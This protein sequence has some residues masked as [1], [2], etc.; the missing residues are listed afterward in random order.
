MAQQTQSMFT[1]A[2]AAIHAGDKSRARE[3]L[4][5]LL[6]IEPS[7]AEYWLW[8][9]AAVPTER[10]R[11][12][13]LKSALKHDPS[14][15]AA[16]RGLIILGARKPDPAELNAAIG[17]PKRSTKGRS[18]APKA[19]R[20]LPLQWI[21]GGAALFTVVGFG[22]LL[23]LYFSRQRGAAPALPPIMF[24]DTPLAALPTATVTPVP[25]ELRINR[26]AIPAEFAATPLAFFIEHT[27]TPT[28]FIGLTPS[29]RYEAYQ[30]A[31][32]A[33]NRAD[34]DEALILINQVLE[35]EPEFAGAHF[36]HGEILR[37]ADKPYEAIRAYDRAIGYQP[38][39]PAAYLGSARAQLL[40]DPTAIP[41]AFQLA[42]N[43]DPLLTDAYLYMA[44]YH[45]DRRHYDKAEEI[46][47]AAVEAGA[48][49]PALRIDLSEAQFL[50]NK[51][52]AALENAV[53]GSADDPA[54]LKG[55]LVLGRAF[56]AMGFYYDALPPLQ[57]FLTYHNEDHRAWAAIG[58]AYLNT[59]EPELALEAFNISLA[60]RDHAPAFQGRGDYYFQQND[61]SS[62]ISDYYRARQFGPDSADLSIGIGKTLYHLGSRQDALRELNAVIASDYPPAIK[63]EAHAYLAMMFETSNP[64]FIPDA[65]ANWLKVLS[66]PEASPELR[67]MA[68]AQLINLQGDDYRSPT[69]APISTA[70][71][72]PEAITTLPAPT[73]AA[74]LTQTPPVVPPTPTPSPTPRGLVP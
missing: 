54:S 15:R 49:S 25:A 66:I 56:V 62:A 26:T 45:S 27:Q 9:S 2:I 31:I 57:T 22:F 69:P 38:D 21:L 70:T 65:I 53:L 8:L 10:E 14:N 64:P 41:S 39:Y 11:L 73:A 61:Y 23:S 42:I 3:L 33:L 63:A 12:F 72:T 30:S 5:R 6:R 71:L 58:K 4:S 52:G 37:L 59:G 35:L 20:Q 36:L 13:C 40:T 19:A 16:L 60:Q 34:Y 28:P 46:L 50:L 1:E 68:E 51:H 47:L 18:P 29:T 44:R 67:S 32:N 55:Y 17:I 7:N 43:Q 74:T 48:V 24:T